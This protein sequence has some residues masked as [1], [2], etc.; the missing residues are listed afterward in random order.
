MSIR[1][2]DWPVIGGELVGMKIMGID[3]CE[4][5]HQRH[6]PN[7]LHDVHL[8]ELQELILQNGEKMQA[9]IRNLISL[10]DVRLKDDA[11]Q[12]CRTARLFAKARSVASGTMHAA[13]LEAS[14]SLSSKFYQSHSN[15]KPP[16][17]FALSHPSSHTPI[18]ESQ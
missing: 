10:I 9:R 11:G 5:I 16:S 4:A 2:C 12:V 1:N 17:S 7:A 3:T 14:A 18:R 8:F 15:L 6:S 13:F